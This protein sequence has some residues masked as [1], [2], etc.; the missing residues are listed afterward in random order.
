MVNQ[1][2]AIGLDVKVEVVDKGQF[3]AQQRAVPTRAM[4]F[5]GGWCADYP[6]Q[7]NWLSVVFGTLAQ[8]GP[9]DYGY[10]SAT[11][12]GMLAEADRGTDQAARDELYL[13]ASRV[14]SADV[15]SIF[16][17]YSLSAALNKPWVGG[18]NESALDAGGFLRPGE[19]VIRRH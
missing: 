18:L 4:L 16:V 14:L 17:A 15:P 7:Q 9:S 2:R 3:Q 11:V 13:K 5:R 12:E 6:D 10:R 1:W 19:I 8:R